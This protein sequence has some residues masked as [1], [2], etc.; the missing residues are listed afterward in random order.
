VLS[1]AS[2]PLTDPTVTSLKIANNDWAVSPDGRYVVF[3]NAAD[4][5]LWL[6]DLGR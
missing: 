1:G 6:L 2:R 4:H 3:V 5:N